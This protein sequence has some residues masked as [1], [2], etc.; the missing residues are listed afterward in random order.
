[1]QEGTRKSATIKH[2]I[3]LLLLLCVAVGVYLA[4]FAPR[5]PVEFPALADYTGSIRVGHGNAILEAELDAAG[6]EAVVR[7]LSGA[8]F[9]SSKEG[10][11]LDYAG[12]IRLWFEDGAEISLTHD[13]QYTYARVTA[14]GSTGYYRLSGTVYEQ[15]YR[16]IYDCFPDGVDFSDLQVWWEDY[17][18]IACSTLME[19]DFNSARELDPSAV[20]EYTFRQMVADGT[21]QEYEIQTAQGARCVIPYRQFL[22]YARQYFADGANAELKETGYYREGDRTMVFSAPAPEQYGS[23]AFGDCQDETQTGGY[24]LVSV[25]RDLFGVLTA[26][27]EDYNEL[28]FNDKGEHT[29]THYFTLLYGSDGRYRFVS[30]RSQIIDPADVSVEGYFL[31]IGR[32]GGITAEVEREWNLHPAGELGGNMLLYY[33]TQGA[34]PTLNLLRVNAK[35]GG[36]TY[37][38]RLQGG[39]GENFWLVQ[40]S[41]DQKQV[42]VLGERT[43]WLLDERLNTVQTISI[44]EQALHTRSFDVSWDGKLLCYTSGEG[45]VLRQLEDGS[46]QLL[47]EHPGQG[48]EGGPVNRLDSPRF[49][50]GGSEI[51]AANV[52]G[53]NVLYYTAYDLS[54]AGWDQ[55]KEDSRPAA[56][57]IDIYPGTVLESY[58]TEDYMVV[59]YPNQDTSADASHYTSGTVHYFEGDTTLSFLLRNEED[60][61]DRVIYGDR[62]YYFERISAADAGDAVFELKVL[63]LSVNMNRIST[64]LRV[65]NAAPKVLAADSAGRGLFSFLSPSGSGMGIADLIKSCE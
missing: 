40:A 1:M 60:A 14:A 7:E 11:G 2:W 37:E 38:A 39:I 33:I 57:T 52:D 58:V 6:A 46:E 30:K 51:V 18:A 44:P 64:G 56:S 55:E 3:K 29:R 12:D 63:E 15:V 47:A 25:H 28:G 9:A 5:V 34:E 35:T 22:A 54:E 43:A 49:V 8:R 21:A 19:E 32:L 62:I 65:V 13:E 26:E 42:K 36:V 10:R 31:N 53:E 48:E 24:R 20:A 4:F 27:V 45:L 17:F 61:P 41:P 59:L 50:M 23:R 16:I